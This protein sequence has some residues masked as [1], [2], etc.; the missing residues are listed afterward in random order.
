ML[1]D[2][3]FGS[4]KSA[5]NSI[6]MLRHRSDEND[7]NQS[8]TSK[9]SR[10]DDELEEQMSKMDLKSRR[11]VEPKSGEMDKEKL[12]SLCEK[13]NKFYSQL[14]DV[15]RKRKQIPTQCVN[16]NK[17]D[18][19]E[20]KFNEAKPTQVDITNTSFL[21]LKTQ[22][23]PSP[24]ISLSNESMYMNLPSTPSSFPKMPQQQQQQPI[25]Q[26]NMQGSPFTQKPQQQII[27]AKAP[28]QVTQASADSGAQHIMSIIDQSQRTIMTQQFQQQTALAAAVQ[29]VPQQQIPVQQP[30]IQ[31]QKQA[32]V[33]VLAYLFLFFDA[34]DI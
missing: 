30:Q 10:E 25:Q 31:Q 22:P 32:P 2:Y 17:L 15:L 16:F 12:K 11:S 1:H 34:L 7:E 20:S 27:S 24:N 21:N 9:A 4:P 29:A 8:L 26:V 5:E 28:V 3:N 33:Q 19:L 6:S 14:Y 18:L 13:N 23:S